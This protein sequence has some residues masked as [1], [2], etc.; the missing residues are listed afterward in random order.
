CRPAPLD[1]AM[2]GQR[3]VDE[4]IS[5]TNS[6]CRIQFKAASDCPEA[7]ADEGLLRHI[8]TNL[9]NNA[10]KYSPPG[11]VVEFELQARNPLAL[12]TVQDRGIGIPESERPLLF[13]AFHR[14]SNV[15]DTPGTGL[16]MTIVKRCVELHGGKIG[17]K[18]KEGHGTTFI[19]AL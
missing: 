10:A 6:R 4:V 9:L 7:Q 1:L 14:G 19:V 16:G 8:F 13:Q 18:S 2:F 15:G 12:F 5:A 11:S 3:L 17:F